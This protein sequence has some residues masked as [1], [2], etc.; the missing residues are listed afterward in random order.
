MSQTTATLFL[1]NKSQALRLPK[2]VAFPPGIEQVT[3]V[4]VG[5]A[6][7]VAPVGQAWDAWFAQ[8][9]EPQAA[10]GPREQPAMQEREALQ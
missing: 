1:N 5:P 3:I 2:A 10:L 7:V 8:T 4:A 6:R 9:P